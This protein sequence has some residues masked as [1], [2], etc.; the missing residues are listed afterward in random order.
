MARPLQELLCDEARVMRSLGLLAFVGICWSLSSAHAQNIAPLLQDRLYLKVDTTT[1]TLVIVTEDLRKLYQYN[2]MANF[3]TTNFRPNESAFAIKDI[4]FS[5]EQ[6]GLKPAHYWNASLESLFNRMTDRNAITF[7]LMLS[8]AYFRFAR[9]LANGQ[10]LDPDLID[11][12]IKMTRKSFEAH[13][14]LAEAAKSPTK[15]RTY[16]ESLTPQHNNYRKLLVALEKLRRLEMVGTWGTLSDPGVDI[17]PGQSH[18][19]LPEIKK[20][21]HDLGYLISDNRT[22]AFDIETQAVVKR[23][24]ELNRIP[25][26]KNI[27]RSFFAS[28]I[29]G[30]AERAERIKANL[31]KFRW[32]PKQWEERY[33]YV[34]LAFQELNIF[35]NQNQVLKMKTVA[36]RPTRRTPTLRDEIRYVELNPT[37]TVPL[38]IAI[39]DKLPQLQRDPYALENQKIWVYDRYGDFVNPANVNWNDY[40]KTNF[41]FTLIQQPGW[42]NALGLVKFPLTNPWFIYLHDTSEPHLMKESNRLK[43]SGCVRLEKAFDLVQYLLKDQPEWP[44]S[45][46]KA[47]KQAQM[48]L[49]LKKNLP[50]YFIYQ[51]VDITDAGEIR[52]APDDYGQDQR[53]IELFKS[54][55]SDEKF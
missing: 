3:W 1:S 41:P 15:L 6:Y 5:A 55:G 44:L 2:G 28:L 10:V 26:I 37:W 4:L 51:T 13:A 43:S 7:E 14:I 42:D 32:F 33:L 53:L 36:G 21:L 46:V 34:N 49:P 48:R 54:R 31:E 45:R 38:S 23:Y 16:L 11:E 24:Q 27:S 50:V 12:D 20:R 19:S 39:K 35:E 9:D 52:M 30:P 47:Q 40:S 22:T 17:K 18:P 8:D 25:V 29:P